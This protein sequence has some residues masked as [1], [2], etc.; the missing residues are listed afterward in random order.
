MHVHCAGP[1]LPVEAESLWLAALVQLEG[2]NAGDALHGPRS[3]KSFSALTR[4]PFDLTD[5]G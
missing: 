5:D 4:I 3:G 2:G 1:S